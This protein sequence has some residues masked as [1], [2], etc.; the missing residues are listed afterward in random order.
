MGDRRHTLLR[1]LQAIVIA[2]AAGLIVLRF[3]A[4][5]AVSHSASD[6]L[7]PWFIQAGLIALAAFAVVLVLGRIGARGRS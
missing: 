3:M 5:D 6:T 4:L 1:L 7:R 2:A